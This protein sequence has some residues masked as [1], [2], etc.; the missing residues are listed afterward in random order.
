MR[1]L[2]TGRGIGKRQRLREVIALLSRRR[3]QWLFKMNWMNCF[4]VM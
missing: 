3:R 1:L 4:H 2:R